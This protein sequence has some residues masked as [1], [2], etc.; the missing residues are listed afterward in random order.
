[1]RIL[2]RAREHGEATIITDPSEAFGGPAAHRDVSVAECVEQERFVTRVAQAAR[3]LFTH[4]RVLILEQRLS[5]EARGARAAQG[6][7]RADRTGAER[8]EIRS[9]VTELE[10]GIQHE[11]THGLDDDL[12][13]AQREQLG[14]TNTK[15][16]RV[17]HQPRRERSGVVLHQRVHALDGGELHRHGEIGQRLHQRRTERLGLR[18]ASQARGTARSENA[19]GDGL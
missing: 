8:L 3:G 1:M 14:R 2:Q 12:F 6:G 17:A 19:G 7:E 10:L 11:P 5:E 4:G 9:R 18:L 15:L 13:A 16:E